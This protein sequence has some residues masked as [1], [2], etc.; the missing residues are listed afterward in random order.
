VAKF[1]G[2]VLDD[3]VVITCPVNEAVLVFGKLIAWWRK[4]GDD[5]TLDSGDRLLDGVP[6]VSGVLDPL[7]I[8]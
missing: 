1:N 4:S 2:L 6:E 8:H 5:V 7:D 3:I